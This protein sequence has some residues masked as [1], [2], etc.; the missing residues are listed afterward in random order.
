V[1]AESTLMGLLHSSG[2]G[3]A[4]T[5]GDSGACAAGVDG[6]MDQEQDS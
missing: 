2:A 1:C 5:G 4:H 6:A 3:P